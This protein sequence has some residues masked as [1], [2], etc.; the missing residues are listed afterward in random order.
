MRRL[1]LP[2][3]ALRLAVGGISGFLMLNA[4]PM[5][6]Q[7]IVPDQTLGNDTSLLR[8]EIQNGVQ[9][10]LIEGGAFREAHLFHSFQDFNVGGG[11]QV[12]F[13]NPLGIEQI[14]SRVTGASASRIDG[15]L[16]VAGPAD[17]FLLNPQGIVF[18]PSAKLDI[19]GSFTGTTATAFEFGNGQKFG[20]LDSGATTG[21]PLLKTT[22][23]PGLQWGSGANPQGETTAGTIQNRADLSIGQ[24]L[25]LAAQ[26]LDLQGQLQARGDLTLQ[27]KDELMVRDR[28]SSPLVVEAGQQLL[29]QGDRS[30][31][32]F[33]LS[34][35]NSQIVATGD[36]MLR[37][38]NSI[39]GDAQF[40]SGGSF[41][42]QQLDQ[43]PGPFY[44][45]RDPVIRAGGDVSFTDYRGSSL[46]V[47]AGG[48]VSADAITILG[49]AVGAVA[50]DFLQ[51][52]VVLSNGA[53]VEIDGSA[54]PTLDIRSGVS[55]AA[56]GNALGTTG[57]A[58][59]FAAAPIDTANATSADINLG[60]VTFEAP[61]GQVFLSNQYRP[62]LSV[63]GGNITLGTL[64]GDDDNAVRFQGNGADFILD[65][66]AD[67]KVVD[68]VDL[69]SAS[70]APGSFDLLA[71]G[72]IQLD[73][74]YLMSNNNGGL[75]PGNISIQTG[76]FRAENGS[77]IQINSAGFNDAGKVSINATGDVLFDGLLPIAS[78]VNPERNEK[79]DRAG[80]DNR[81]F[82]SKLPNAPLI[83]SGGVEI[84]AKN[85]T[86]SNGAQLQVRV[87]IGARGESGDIRF[88]A[89][90]LIAVVG[91]SPEATSPNNPSSSALITSIEPD[92]EG[93][94]G[95]IILE[96]ARI[97]MLDG[98]GLQ[99][100]T[101][102]LGNAGNIFIS[103]SESMQIGGGRVRR[104]RSSIQSRVNR[105][106]GIGQGGDITIFTPVLDMFDTVQIRANS[107][108]A[109]SDK[110]RGNSGKI[111]IVA[112]QRVSIRD[113]AQLLTD[114]EERGSFAGDISIRTGTFELLDKSSIFSGANSKEVGSQ[115]GG[116]LE[117]IATQ[118]V[119]V[120]GESEIRTNQR[121]ESLGNA[122]DILI[123]SPDIRI[124]NGSTVFS[125][126]DGTGNGGSISFQAGEGSILLD[127]DVPVRTNLEEKGIGK[128]GNILLNANDITLSN[129]GRFIAGTE[130][131]GP[132]GDIM[133]QVPGSVVIT[134]SSPATADCARDCTSGFYSTVSE[135]AAA[136]SLSR[137]GSITGVIEQLILRDGGRIDVSSD[138]VGQ[139][140][141][142]DLSLNRLELNNGSQIRSA[143]TNL[144]AGGN[145]GVVAR[146]SITIA[147]ESQIAASAT[148]TA[149]GDAGNITLK[150][151]QLSLKNRAA[152]LVNSA[153]LGDGGNLEI[154]AQAIA[155]DNQSR[156]TAS[157]A[158]GQGGNL[159]FTADESLLLRRNS[160]ITT[161]AGR[162][163][164][165]GNITLTT[166]FL[167]AISTEDSNISANAR[168]GD[169]GRV[170]ISAQ[171]VLGLEFRPQSTPLSDITASSESGNQGIVALNTPNTDPVS[172]ITELPGG[173]IDSANAVSRQC[174]D[175]VV[176]GQSSLVISGQGG[177]PTRPGLTIG[178]TFDT[179]QVR[180]LDSVL[181]SAVS[182]WGDVL[183]RN[184]APAIREATSWALSARGEVKLLGNVAIAS[185]HQCDDKRSVVQ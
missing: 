55:A 73:Q 19:A 39:I 116:D 156:L 43:S 79:E 85:I 32:I 114:V 64:L 4:G 166:P 146:D 102:G 132:G 17:L 76:S 176:A 90:D 149:Q 50:E 74:S 170:N 72:V 94:A 137:G 62:N 148:E 30:L 23:R 103:A 131:N 77:Q 20:F 109:L 95:D 127:N 47:L 123:E 181:P 129:G 108:P 8:T 168:Q 28:V 69:S 49:A 180:S 161:N 25:Q 169:G 142:T 61:N 59:G 53:V 124:L 98:G 86:V 24:D 106:G 177:L 34:H 104:R 21:V 41:Q 118:S 133:V 175:R 115:G 120:D 117:I 81:M 162:S 2:E 89:Q 171:G 165:G 119:L 36:L 6:A 185:R 138:N 3:L 113:N 183:D 15:L 182:N 147:N 134:G 184:A 16:G 126:S 48:Q 1:V 56:L 140:G 97:Q 122:G 35:P 135:N 40:R 112:P 58:T 57:D 145:I 82:D 150:T 51:E 52:T 7:E 179:G 101:I 99:S 92:G 67:F 163:G 70:G 159:R 66:R 158:S 93:K 37:S 152:A 111:T 110:G 100:N 173:L 33:A 121:T 75:P 38:G 157:T 12:Y 144:G 155:L 125:L 60:Q 22:L 29:L 153:G 164:N 139:A 31:D 174:A 151:G 14:F 128:A 78:Q 105:E 172:G 71:K 84:N 54:R 130:G 141:S 27:A 91:P 10:E 65:S 83:A 9:V 26:N 160:E 107:Q 136:N 13:V 11:Q 96:G 5:L 63:G 45:P 87:D 46:H 18:G 167:V 80:I 178:N 44:S 68:R 42:V 154:E 143:T 88:T